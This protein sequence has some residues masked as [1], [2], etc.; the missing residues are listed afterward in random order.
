MRTTSNVLGG[1]LQSCCLQP[2][3][4]FYRD[5]YC[6]TGPGDFGLHTVCAQMTKEFLL[7]SR[8]QG[9]DLSTPAPDF[10]FPGL[11]PGDRW[12]LCVTRWKE[13]YDAGQAPPVF[14]AATHISALEY[15]SLEELKEHALDH[16]VE[17]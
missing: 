13:A 15:V 5:G 1:T 8:R 12:C 14:L 7:F 9:N 3:T 16:P 4:G 11:Q 10:D 6:H 2:A 17:G